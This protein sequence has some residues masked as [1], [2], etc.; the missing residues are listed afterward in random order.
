MTNEEYSRDALIAHVQALDTVIRNRNNQIAALKAQLA[1]E[2]PVSL[3]AT[4]EKKIKAAYKKGWKDCYKSV[5]SDVLTELRR[6]SE[7]YEVN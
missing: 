5:Y 6:N 3:T 4:A 7:P 2:A 1:G